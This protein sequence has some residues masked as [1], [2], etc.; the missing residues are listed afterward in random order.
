VAQPCLQQADRL[1]RLV[2]DEVETAFLAQNQQKLL[3]ISSEI[4]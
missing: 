3:K 2:R 4:V 1:E